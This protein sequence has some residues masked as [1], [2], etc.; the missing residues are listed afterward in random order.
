MAAKTLDSVKSA[1]AVRREYSKEGLKKVYDLEGV[2]DRYEDKLGNYLF[3][4]TAGDLDEEQ[5]A[6]V[7]KYL[8]VLSDFERISDHA[9]NIGEAVAEINERKIL[10]SDAAS[11]ELTVLENAVED[12][13]RMTIE[14]FINN[15]SDLALRV[16]PLEEVV[17]DLCDGIKANHIERVSKQECT[18]ENGFVFNDLLTDYERISDHC[19]NVA[20][21]V[22]ESV[23]GYRWLHEF[24]SKPEYRENAM[25]KRAYEEFSEIYSID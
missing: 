4:I 13:T 15:D 14:A 23:P 9:R 21:D 18:L 5:S 20:I 1:I 19:S 7:S 3:K 22:I 10:L 25:Y 16:D 2:M 17:D 6:D 12:I 24:H 11:K 8:R